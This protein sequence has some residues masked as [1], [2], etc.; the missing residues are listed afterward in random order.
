MDFYLLQKY[1][2]NK[3]QAKNH[4]S[5]KQINTILLVMF[6]LIPK[7]IKISKICWFSASPL[8]FFFFFSFSKVLTVFEGWV[9]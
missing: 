9:T 6:F 2:V 7:R 8:L 1:R 4:L 5:Q 3:N